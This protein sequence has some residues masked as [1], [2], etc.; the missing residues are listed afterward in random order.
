MYSRHSCN[1]RVSLNEDLSVSLFLSVCLCLS[2]CAFASHGRILVKKILCTHTLYRQT[3]LSFSDSF[4]APSLGRTHTC[5]T[6]SLASPQPLVQPEPVGVPWL[7]ASS[8][9]QD[10]SPIWVSSEDG[11]TQNSRN[12]P[13]RFHETSMFQGLYR[14]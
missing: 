7:R 13:E 14:K 6:P 3:L 2:V 9:L 10:R 8:V 4:A 1:G 5:L 12:L 11:A